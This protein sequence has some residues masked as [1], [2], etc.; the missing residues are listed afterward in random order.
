MRLLFV[1]LAVILVVL[2]VLKLSG[3][4]DHDPDAGTPAQGESNSEE[5]FDIDS[6]ARAEPMTPGNETEPGP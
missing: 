1:A 3:N 5:R 4:L 6:G 2:A